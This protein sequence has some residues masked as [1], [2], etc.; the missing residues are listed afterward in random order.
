MSKYSIGTSFLSMILHQK[1]WF[2]SYTVFKSIF[3]HVDTCHPIWFNNH[4][5]LQENLKWIKATYFCQIFTIC[6]IAT[7]SQV[8]ISVLCYFAHSPFFHAAYQSQT[9]HYGTYI[10][11]SVYKDHILWD[12]F[13]N[14]TA[15]SSLSHRHSKGNIDNLHIKHT[16]HKVIAV[17]ENHLKE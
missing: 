11:F 10:I 13:F 3:R 8:N 7:F 2:R 12:I 1:S 16:S 5:R 9:F 4:K 14:F 6:T 17:N 15:K